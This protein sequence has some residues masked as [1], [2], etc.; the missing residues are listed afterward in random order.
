MK[1]QTV[2]LDPIIHNCTGLEYLDGVE[3][4][5]VNDDNEWYCYNDGWTAENTEIYV[6]KGKPTLLITIGESWT[7]G[8]GTEV[9]NHRYHKWR[10][11]DR[12]EV[13]YS[14]KMARLLDS[15]LWTFGLP[16]NSNSGIFTALSRIL[17]NIPKGR[18][19]SIKVAVLMTACDRDRCDMIPNSHPLQDLINPARK[20]KEDE[21]ITFDEWLV[22]YDEI[23][24]NLLDKEIKKHSDLNIDAV[25][26][27][28][29]NKIWTTRRDYN[30]KI[31]D[32]FWLE[33][34]AAWF[35]ITLKTCKVMHPDFFQAAMEQFKIL[36]PIDIDYINREFDDWENLV[37]FLET[38]NEMNLA[39]HP[40]QV[41]HSLWTK[42]LLDYTGW[43]LI[44]KI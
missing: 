37:K 36:K 22:R 11:R 19:E 17:D 39:C 24:F 14:G 43:K 38:N 20:F 8:E 5:E 16:G 13:T 4:V 32:T 23:F 18:Y 40:T 35:G 10:V 6:N 29:F 7:Y 42:F 44:S 33:Y 9:I 41:S 25:L 30:F 12:I 27:K 2:T 3:T 34:N 28:N 1:W 15:D 26:F 31:I 21:K